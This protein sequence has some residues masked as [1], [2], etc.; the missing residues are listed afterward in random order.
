LTFFVNLFQDYTYFTTQPYPATYPWGWDDPQIY[1]VALQKYDEPFKADEFGKLFQ[2]EKKDSSKPVVKINFDNLDERWES[3][4]AKPGVQD[5]P[6]VIQKDSETIVLFNSNHDGEASSIWKYVMKPFDK[7]ETKKIS[8]A[9]TH[10]MFVVEVKDKHYALIKGNIHKLNLSGNKTEKID[11]SYKF[12]KNLRDEFTQMFYETWT[13]LDENY[14]NG[15]FKG[16]DWKSKRDYYKQFIPKLRSRDDLRRM[17]DDLMGE[18]NSSHLGFRSSGDE[19][20]TYYE[21]NSLVTGILFENDKPFTVKRIVKNSPADKE[22]KKILPGDVLTKV[23]GEVVAGKEDREKYFLSKSN[24][25]ELNLTFERNGQAYNVNIHP[26]NRTALYDLLYTEWEDSRQEIVDEKGGNRISYIHM[27][28][29]TTPELEKFYR[30]VTHEYNYKDAL[31]LD[32][33]YNRGGNVHDRVLQLLSQRQ[34]VQWKYRD[35]KFTSQPNFCPSDKPIVLL[36]NEQSLSDAELT[37]VGFKELDLGK[38]VGTESYRWLIFTTNVRMIDGS[39]YRLP[40]WGCYYND[41]KDI[42]TEGAK[43]DIYVDNTFKDRLENKDPQLERAVEEILK[44][45]Q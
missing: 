37:A 6:Y 19:E 21:Y 13:N 8:D 33:R 28:Y 24:G 41:G 45:L 3:V 9:D 27:R 44:E 38:I 18:L 4:I 11:I 20:D 1:R 31:I 10:G 22:D 23:N 25:K 35:G 42:E 17:M 32:L 43:P 15:T 2:E 7:N 5:N 40:S 14:Y 36:I 12:E 30:E 34:Y 16:V 29:M 39:R 26:I